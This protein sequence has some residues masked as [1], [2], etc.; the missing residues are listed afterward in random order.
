MLILTRRIGETL[1]IGDEVTV[2]VLGV[3]G[4]QVRIGVNAP[5][6]VSVHREEIYAKIQGEKAANVTPLSKRAR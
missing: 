2:T 6:E 5:K 3:Q 4:Q 1:M